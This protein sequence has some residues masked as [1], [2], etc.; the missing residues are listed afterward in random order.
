MKKQHDMI[1][2]P[3]EGQKGVCRYECSKCGLPEV[4][5]EELGKTD[6]CEGKPVKDIDWSFGSLL[7]QIE[8]RQVRRVRHSMRC[9]HR[10]A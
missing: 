8:Q 7:D 6:D 4:R 2:V 5:I 3:V 10:V 9:R 1:V